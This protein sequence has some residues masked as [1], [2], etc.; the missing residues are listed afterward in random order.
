MQEVRIINQLD[1]F[2]VESGNGHAIQHSMV[3]GDAY[4]HYWS[5]NPLPV[6][7]NRPAGFIDD[8]AGPA[9][10]EYIQALEPGKLLLL[11]NVQY[12]TEEV[13]IFIKFVKLTPEQLGR[14]IPGAQS[15]PSGRLLHF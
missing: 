7:Y 14:D 8:I 3:E 11:N 5:H 1:N 9:A 2:I 13:S 15:R 12:L 6:S 4:G 10:I